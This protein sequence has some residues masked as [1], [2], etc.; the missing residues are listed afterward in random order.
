MGNR[1]A[2][3]SQP[4]SKTRDRISS[5]F[6]GNSTTVKLPGEYLFGYLDSGCRVFSD[7]I[8][9]LRRLSQRWDFFMR[10]SGTSDSAE[11]GTA[12]RCPCQSVENLLGDVLENRLFP[13]TDAWSKVLCDDHDS[14]VKILGWVAH[15]VPERRQAE[16]GW[17]ESEAHRGTSEGVK[18]LKSY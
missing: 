17:Q 9:V 13:G 1:A 5:P 3:E 4:F 15:A 12:A 2:G 7:G 8:V 14:Q 10:G 16:Q 11:S 18:V 6:L